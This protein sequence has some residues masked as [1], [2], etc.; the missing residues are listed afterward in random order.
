M[1]D[2]QLRELLINQKNAG[3]DG[4]IRLIEEELQRCMRKGENPALDKYTISDLIDKVKTRFAQRNTTAS[5]VM[6]HIIK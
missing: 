2:D 6:D 3:H 1:N 4:T 5:P